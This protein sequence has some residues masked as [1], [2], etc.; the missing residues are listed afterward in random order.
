MFPGPE[1]DDEARTVTPPAVEL[2]CATRGSNQIPGNRE[3]ESGE[4]SIDSGRRERLKEPVADLRRD[5]PTVVFEPECDFPV[6]YIGR[7]TDPALR[8][9]PACLGGVQQEIEQRMLEVVI[10]C[11]HGGQRGQERA[12]QIESDR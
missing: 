11:C 3:A 7:H 8:P 6:R 1:R 5:P 4:G 12:A 9:I 2:Q 10:H